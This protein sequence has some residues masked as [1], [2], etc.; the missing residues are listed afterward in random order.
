MFVLEKHNNIFIS[1]KVL[2]IL[3]TWPKI[4]TKWFIFMSRTVFMLSETKK[5][6]RFTNDLWPFNIGILCKKMSSLERPTYRFIFEWLHSKSFLMQ[7]TFQ[8]SLSRWSGLSCPALLFIWPSHKIA[9]SKNA[10]N[11]I[12]KTIITI[13]IQ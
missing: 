10:N 2:K 8:A 11:F 3:M 1:K 13:S 6:K 12:V 5:N 7:I 4:K 9:R